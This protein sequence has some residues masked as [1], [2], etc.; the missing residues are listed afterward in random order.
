MKKWAYIACILSCFQTEVKAQDVH[1]S[2]QFNLPSLVNPAFTNGIKNT[3]KLTAAN[4][5][6]WNSVT[7]PYL[8]QLFFAEAKVGQKEALFN[9]GIGFTN[10]VAGDGNYTQRTYDFRVS[11][12]LFLNHQKNSALF[13]GL[14]AGYKSINYDIDK[15]QFN[16][17]YN[18][19]FNGQLPNLENGAN[20]DLPQILIG[21]GIG[22]LL[23]RNTKSI[24]LGASFKNLNNPKY[25]FYESGINSLGMLMEFQFGFRSV[26]QT[27][28][29]EIY[30]LLSKQ[31]KHE[32]MLVQAIVKWPGLNSRLFPILALGSRINDA[33]IPAVG[34]GSRVMQGMYSFDL[35]RSDLTKSSNGYGAHEITLI[36]IFTPRRK[37]T[38]PKFCPSFI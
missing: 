17:Q 27:S 3:A 9:I 14:Q 36:Y 37:I 28:V 7:V 15:F 24:V 11:K 30:T 8:T 4:R 18:N 16:N 35:N 12:F 13:F 20:P 1:F 21:S 32:K 2:Q 22:I 10:D 33:F 6:Q 29:F 26:G 31:Q 23:E 19:G 5:T 38:D 34:I 25:S